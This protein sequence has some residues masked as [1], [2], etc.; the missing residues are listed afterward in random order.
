MHRKGAAH[1]RGT[2][3]KRTIIT[4]DM[5]SAKDTIEKNPD[6]TADEILD[7]DIVVL[8]KKRGYRFSIDA[9]LLTHF[10]RI[11][12][13]AWIVEFGTGSAVIAMVIAKRYPTAVVHALEIQPQIADMAR[14]SVE[15]N[16][17]LDRVTIHNEDARAVT[18]L[19]TERRFDA[20]VF[21]PPYRKRNS[22]RINPARE[23]AVARHEI[24]GSLSL[25]LDAA[26][27]IV[28]RGASVY[29]IYP[30]RRCVDL[31][32]AMR[33]QKIE[34][35][36]MRMVHSHIGSRAEFVMVE[37]IKGAG[38]EMSVMPPLFLYRETN[39]YSEE[40]SAIFRELAT[41]P[42]RDG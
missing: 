20:A 9:L 42:A 8:Q 19:F 22:G 33:A 41:F 18:K 31:I 32:T 39:V 30:A 12:K 23:K 37:G 17:L 5:A 2:G 4:V 28:T 34:P 21:N 27:S 16:G 26:G 35:K 10:V 1:G 11:R 13:G 7:A 3:R 14:R 6:E 25:F 40:M 15:A 29:T 38:E 36:R 24:A